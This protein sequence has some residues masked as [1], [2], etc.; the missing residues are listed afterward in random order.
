MTNPE[1]RTIDKD[2]R[3]RMLPFTLLRDA[4]RVV[5]DRGIQID[6][7]NEKVQHLFAQL[8]HVPIIGSKRVQPAP[9]HAPTTEQDVLVLGD[10]DKDEVV[11]EVPEIK[12]KRGRRKTQPNQ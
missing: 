11:Y 6:D 4:K 8:P 12:P 7:M 1:I 3:V 10:E 5:I 9:S 2:G